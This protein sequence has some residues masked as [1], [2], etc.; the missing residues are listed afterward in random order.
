[1]LHPRGDFLADITALEEID[2]M[3][4]LG[5]VYTAD[6]IQNEN[7][8]TSVFM[9]AEIVRR[10]GWMVPPGITH[11]YCDNAWK[12]IGEA[13]GTLT[14]LDDVLVEHMHPMASK[15]PMDAGYAEVNSAHRYEADRAAYRQWLAAG[16]P[17]DMRRV[18]RGAQH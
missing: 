12:N 5:V 9:D 7:L 1:V 10:L 18:M 16:L 13:L 8:P 15:A 14:Y 6:G 2:A 4:P 17:D 3:Q 11:L